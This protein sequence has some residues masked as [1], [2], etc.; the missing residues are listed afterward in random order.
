MN[1]KVIKHGSVT[2]A[3]V[4]GQALSPWPS[5]WK[6]D[7]PKTGK[8]SATVP[9]SESQFAHSLQSGW[10]CSP[11]WVGKGHP[12]SVVGLSPQLLM[13]RTVIGIAVFS[14]RYF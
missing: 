9:L 1:E 7:P 4:W 6:Q 11:L 2:N 8:S 12:N 10:E 5:P 13:Q 14:H 3:Y